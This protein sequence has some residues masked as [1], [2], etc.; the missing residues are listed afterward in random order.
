MYILSLIEFSLLLLFGIAL[1]MAFANIKFDKENIIIIFVLFA[2]FG[3]IQLFLYLTTTEEVVRRLYPLITH[4]PLI[5]FIILTYKKRLSTAIAATTSAYLCCQPAKWLGLFIYFM[6]NN[7]MLQSLTTIAVYILFGLFVIAYIAEYVAKIYSKDDRSIYIFG[8]I[9]MVYYL[10]DYSLNIYLYDD[11]IFTQFALEF[12][13]FF[14]C[15]VYLLFCSVY[16]KEH[17]QKIEIEQQNKFIQFNI[18]QQTKEMETLKRSEKEIRVLRHDLRLLL[19]NLSISI[20]QE[21]K[22]NAQRMIEG[23]ITQIDNTVIKRYCE[24]TTINYVLLNFASRCKDEGIQFITDIELSKHIPND[25]L[26][27]IL[28]SNALDNACNAQKELHEKQRYIKLS[29][30]ISNN[31]L[32]I[33]IKNPFKTAPVFVDGIPTSNRLGHGYGIQSILATVKELHGN[34]QFSVNGKEFIVRIII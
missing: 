25:I 13:P 1:S 16:Y 29:L 10:Y 14:L 20:Q 11:I 5:A 33:L 31:K 8:I 28:L 17:E 23:Y 24:N 9:P 7:E 21:D 2:I 15:I 30:K 4:I 19:S 32:L 34:C 26:L 3:G 18:D 6:T 27:S 22:E 12:L